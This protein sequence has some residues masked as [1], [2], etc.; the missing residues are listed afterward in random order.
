MTEKVLSQVQATDMAISQVF[1]R[2]TLRN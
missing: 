1:Y 2:M